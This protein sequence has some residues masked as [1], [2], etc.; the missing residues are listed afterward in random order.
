ML[1]RLARANGYQGRLTFQGSADHAHP[2]EDRLLLQSSQGVGAAGAVELVT[3]RRPSRRRS[4]SSAGMPAAAAARA[5][6][7]SAAASLRGVSIDLLAGSGRLPDGAG[8]QEGQQEGTPLLQQGGAAAGPAAPAE[9][10]L[11]PSPFGGSWPRRRSMRL[12]QQGDGA[13][14]GEAHAAPAP[15]PGSASVFEPFASPQQ[16]LSQGPSQVGGVWVHG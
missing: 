2:G 11:R 3:R 16:Q 1:Q 4:G 13:L 7:E 10:L 5:G 6:L 15:L 8:G 14:A 9:E 12:R